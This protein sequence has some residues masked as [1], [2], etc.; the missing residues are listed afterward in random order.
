MAVKILPQA[1]IS[2]LE[3]SLT[4]FNVQKMRMLQ[5]IKIDK[6]VGMLLQGKACSFLEIR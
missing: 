1:E 4:A 5:N 2:H 3:R 6:F